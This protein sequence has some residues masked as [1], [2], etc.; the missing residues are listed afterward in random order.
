MKCYNGYFI[1]EHVFYTEKY[2]HSRKTYNN[3]VY[4]KGSTSNK[5]EVDYYE[6]LEEDIELQYYSEQDRVFFIKILLV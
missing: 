5:F 2:G 1:N 3:E 6:K 4:V